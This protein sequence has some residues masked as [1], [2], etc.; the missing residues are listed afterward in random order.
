[1]NTPHSPLSLHRGLWVL[2]AAVLLLGGCTSSRPYTLGP[3]KTVDPDTTAIP[4]PEEK[5]EIDLWDRID[6]TLFY[7]LEKP[8]N[9]A[10]LGRQVGRMLDIADKREADNVN[11]LGEVPS[12]SWYTRRHYYEPMTRD[13]LATGPNVTGGPDRSGPWTVVSGKTTG[14]SPGFVI[15]DARGDRYVLK[16]SP[17]PYQEMSPAAE[18]IST[19]IL[20]AAGYYVP[21]NYVTFFDP[22][23]LTI[24][25]TAMIN[26]PQGRRSME[27]GD[28]S[29][30]LERQPRERGGLVRTMASKYVEGQP[31]GIWEFR[32][33]RDDDPNDRVFHQHRRELRGLRVISAWLNDADR[34]SA[35]TLATYTD[36][37]YVK[38]YLLDMGSTLGANGPEPHSPKHGHENIYDVSKILASTFAFGLYERP[39]L[40]LNEE[41]EILY[42]SVGYFESKLFEPGEWVPVYPNPAFDRM[43]LR[44]AFWGAKI[45]TSFSDED[46]EAIV[47]TAEFSNPDAEAYLL[48]TLQERRDKIGRYYFSRI[49][50]LDRFALSRSASGELVL[51]FD[52]L[53]VES[54]LRPQSNRSY[55][56]GVRFNGQLLHDEPLTANEAR[57]PLRNIPATRNVAPENR[58]LRVKIQTRDADG[59]LSLP[60]TVYGHVPPSGQQPRVIGI[61]RD[62]D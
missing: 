6:M 26:T 11:V 21:E 56:Y 22:D 30:I 41:E 35:N 20:Y 43:T 29:L 55:I 15:E 62:D 47:E 13:E 37:G 33:T 16:F 1:M 23:N 58:I 5:P 8:F 2:A 38:H 60:V 31:L 17:A 12:S 4:K 54:N 25:E 32:G 7:Q 36:N 28:I 44:D 9:L 40:F 27:P 24:S 50:P 19:K 53:A 49:N 39:W 18:V 51:S 61:H 46:L 3:I 59:S 14:A 48:R 57:L 45:V 42:P 10:W 34:R 52:D